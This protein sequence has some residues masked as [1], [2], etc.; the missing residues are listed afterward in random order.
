MK[1]GS[2]TDPFPIVYPGD[3]AMQAVSPAFITLVLGFS[4]IFHGKS[5][6]AGNLPE[7]NLC[8]N[9]RGLLCSDFLAAGFFVLLRFSNF[10]FPASPSQSSLIYFGSHRVAIDARPIRSA[11]RLHRGR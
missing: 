6:A 1:K 7:H 9:L 2:S 8:P 3:P 4:I 5:P 10:S 11:A